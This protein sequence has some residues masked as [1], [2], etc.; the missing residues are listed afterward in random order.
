VTIAMAHELMPSRIGLISGLFMG[1]AMGAGGI[2]VSVSG[3]IA[4][5]FGLT[6]TLS[7][8]PALILVT[9]LL[10]AVVGYPRRG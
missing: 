1:I 4:D 6:A 8:F 9:T 7:V 10:F 3:V 5:H 2:G